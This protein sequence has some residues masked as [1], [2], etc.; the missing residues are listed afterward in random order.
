[1]D[2]LYELGRGETF[3]TTPVAPRAAIGTSRD[4]RDCPALTHN[5]EVAGSDLA[6]TTAGSWSAAT[7]P[8]HWVD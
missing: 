2:E 5:P 4:C 3:G 1:M 6:P 8:L 7:E